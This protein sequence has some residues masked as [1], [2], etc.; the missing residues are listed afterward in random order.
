MNNEAKKLFLEN[1][2]NRGDCEG[3]L[4]KTKIIE[5]EKENGAS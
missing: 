4:E 2:F 5:K 1:Y 3:L